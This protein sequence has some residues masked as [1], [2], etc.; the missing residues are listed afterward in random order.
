[1][2]AKTRAYGVVFVFRMASTLERRGIVSHND[3]FL[4]RLGVGYVL[5]AFLEPFHVRFVLGVVVCDPPVSDAFK[6]VCKSR[7]IGSDISAVC[8]PALQHW[9]RPCRPWSGS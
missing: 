5:Q 8:N 4:V 1:M 6:V 9:I 7:V 2:T 3:D